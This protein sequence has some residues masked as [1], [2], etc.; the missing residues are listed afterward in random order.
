MGARMEAG[1][2]MGP[3]PQYQS[4]AKALI[5][6]SLLRYCGAGQS[7]QQACAARH[8]EMT[9]FRSPIYIID[10][11]F[12]LSIGYP[13]RKVAG[14]ANF[15]PNAIVRGAQLT[16]VGGV[17]FYSPMLEMEADTVC[18]AHRALQNPQLLTSDHYRQAALAVAAGLAIRILIAIPVRCVIGHF[19]TILLI[20]TGHC[21]TNLRLDT[22][23]L[24]QPRS[25]QLGQ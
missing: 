3:I 15:E 21:R 13:L 2:S 5:R 14:M 16:F 22:W 20:S 19:R 11:L 24:H 1:A 23:F 6:L 4:P 12:D 17:P 10:H 7:P 18:S 25:F 8:L 9:V